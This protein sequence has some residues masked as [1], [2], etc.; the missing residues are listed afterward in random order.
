M[1]EQNIK[2][3]KCGHEFA[4]TEAMTEKIAN[5]YREK[6]KT[7]AADLQT[8]YEQKLDE[9]RKGFEQK[10]KEQREAEVAR[11]REAVSLELKDMQAQLAEKQQ[12]LLQAQEQELALRKKE[13]ELTEKA[14]SIELEMTRKLAA[15]RGDIETAAR[16]RADEEHGLRLAEKDKQLAD[17]LKQLE[18]AKRKLEQGSQQT[19][20]EI[21][22]LELEEQLKAN[23]PEDEIQPVAKG[24]RG[25]DV[26]QR[27]TTGGEPGIILWEFKNTKNWTDGWISK[28]KQDMLD[29]RADMAVIVSR[30]L[31]K[32]MTGFGEKDGVMI[33]DFA[34]AIGLGVVLRESLIKIIYAK[35]SAEGVNYKTELIYKY[36]VGSEFQQ[37]I[38]A[39]VDSFKQ[40]QK[41]L[42][43]ERRAI[44][45][46]WTKRSTQI[47]IMQS[48]TVAI[49]GKLHAII[50]D[51]LLDIPM[52][53]APPEEGGSVAANGDGS[54]GF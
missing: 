7:A 31:P 36:L 10:A 38:R 5:E 44:M 20:G 45:K 13:R 16:K 49:H 46:L 41:D 26:I 24:V 30:T 34:S 37:R 1:P 11:A 48:S 50:G 18:E 21:L 17:T 28:L 33:C 23:F 2:C 4:V 35:T 52:L 32:G 51:A 27:I 42:D 15:E 47:E 3:P 12:K 25:G 8:K 43:D 39:I 40:M 22:E 9:E 19:Q 29:C 6:Y 54:L 53:A 14:Q